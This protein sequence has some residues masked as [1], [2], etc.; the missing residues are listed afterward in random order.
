MEIKRGYDRLV[1]LIP[2]LQIALKFPRIYLRKALPNIKRMLTSKKWLYKEIFEWNIYSFATLKQWLFKGMVE[3]WYE[4]SFY[5]R[6]RHPFCVPTYFSFL[7][8]LNIQR[9]ASISQFK[10]TDLW[11]QLQELA[12]MILISKGSHH[13]TEPAN[14]T[15]EN[16]RL[17]IFD[18]GN[19]KVQE[20][21]IQYGQKILDNFDPDYSWE[22]RKQELS[23]PPHKATAGKGRKK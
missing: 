15:F 1:I 14:F 2:S 5:I 23:P 9:L 13:L 10:T 4:Y 19:Q 8:L 11:C 17:Q 16:N 21:I 12:D 3:N 7:G 6:T 20:V 22:K 18:Y